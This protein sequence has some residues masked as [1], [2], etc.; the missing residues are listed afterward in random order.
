[1]DEVSGAVAAPFASLQ[2]E[3][4]DLFV[5]ARCMVPTDAWLLR[6][7]LVAGGVPAVVADANHVQADLLIAPAL[8]G[9]RILAPGSYLAQA[10]DIIAAF[11]RGEFALDD[12]ADVG[13]PLV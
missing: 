11:E 5:V 4:R 9:V 8:G 12:D 7:V 2:L 3:G 10:A 6:G 1:M 13:A